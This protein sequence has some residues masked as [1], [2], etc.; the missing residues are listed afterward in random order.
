MGEPALLPVMLF[1]DRCGIRRVPKVPGDHF[2]LG[3]F[4]LLLKLNSDRCPPMNDVD[5]LSGTVAVKLNSRQY[6]ISVNP[7]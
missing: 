5:K 3:G 6:S 1:R 2:R 4:P 7:N